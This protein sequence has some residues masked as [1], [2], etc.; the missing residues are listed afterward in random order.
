MSALDQWVLD[1]TDLDGEMLE[2]GMLTW[3]P[4][5]FEGE[6]AT[7]VEGMLYIGP[8]PPGFFIGVV[9]ASG[10]DAVEGWCSENRNAIDAIRAGVAEREEKADP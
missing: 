10:Q 1:A 2:S 7:L 8:L 6:A 4:V 5:D 9:H 3:V